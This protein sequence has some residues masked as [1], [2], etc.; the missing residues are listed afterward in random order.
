[1]VVYAA[2]DVK[3][4]AQKQESQASKFCLLSNAVFLDDFFDHVV[5]M[6]DKKHKD[7]LLAARKAKIKQRLW[8]SISDEYS[9]LGK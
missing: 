4:K 1:M 5:K 8:S 7:E 9:D 6:N 2:Q 3:V